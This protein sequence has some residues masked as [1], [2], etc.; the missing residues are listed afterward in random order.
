MAFAA[1]PSFRV[2]GSSYLPSDRYLDFGPVFG[3]Q[4]KIVTLGVRGTGC[5]SNPD[6]G[7]G[8]YVKVSRSAISVGLHGGNTSSGSRTQ[9][10]VF[11][12]ELRPSVEEALAAGEPVGP[13]AVDSQ[14]RVDI[15]MEKNLDPSN[16]SSP[17]HHHNGNGNGDSSDGS[18]GN[19]EF[20]PGGGGGS[21][22]DGN[23]EHSGSNGEEDEFGPILK[24]EEVMR[25]TEARGVKLP[26]DMYEAAKIVG[27]RKAFM[28]NYLA[29][30]V[31]SIVNP[32]ACSWD[33]VYTVALLCILT[34]F[35]H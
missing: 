34:W 23:D 19:R 7:R 21:G 17:L 18:G 31:R 1:P 3:R 5:G 11:R 14:E 9:N 12:G 33:G 25:E 6:I 28:D 13:K 29:L 2:S 26:S 8:L 30:Q 24:F 10:N 20:P 16:T 27:I 22:G 35:L 32:T 4:K 15:S